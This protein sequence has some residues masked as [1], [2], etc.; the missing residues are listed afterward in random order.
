M[1]SCQ[2]LPFRN[3]PVEFC[4]PKVNPLKW[5]YSIKCDGRFY[6]TC[7]TNHM[8]PL[9]STIIVFDE[10]VVAQSMRDDLAQ[11]TAHNGRRLPDVRID[12]G[13]GYMSTGVNGALP[14]TAI[15]QL[16][17]VRLGD[18]LAFA[19]CRNVGIDMILGD[20]E[21]SMCKTVSYSTEGAPQF[22]EYLE[23]QLSA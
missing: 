18:L 5:V 13:T 19:S 7:H 17:P 23:H 12:V 4:R 9:Q 21:G 6:G 14:E 20:P 2:G 1:A 16:Y 15:L 3:I 22:V 11:I 10:K 8:L